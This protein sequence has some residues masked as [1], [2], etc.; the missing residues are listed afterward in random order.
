MILFVVFKKCAT[1]A[2]AID[3]GVPL[4]KEIHT[5]SQQIRT[6]SSG[7]MGEWLKPPVC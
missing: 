3:K 1:F 7:R 2:L 4:A 5:E 6:H